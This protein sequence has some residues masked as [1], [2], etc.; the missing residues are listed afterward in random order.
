[1]TRKKIKNKRM[2]FIL[3]LLFFTYSISLAAQSS[4]EIWLDEMNLSAMTCGWDLPK[5]NFSV[6]GWQKIK[7]N[8]ETFER[9]VGSHA[10]SEFSISLD[11]KATLFSAKV[12]VDDRASQWGNSA[13]VIFKVYL[14]NKLAFVSDTMRA[15]MPSKAL[16]VNLKKAKIL[17]LVIDDAGDGQHADQADWAMAKIIYNAKKPKPT[18]EISESNPYL[19]AANI[20]KKPSINGPEIYG[21]RTGSPFLYRIPV[22][23]EKPISINIQGLPDGLTFDAQKRI[24]SGT[25]T[26]KGHYITTV[27]AKN[28]FGADKRSFE[29]VIGDTILLT[30]LMGW[31]SW[32]AY[33]LK[34]N[35]ETVKKVADFFESTGLVDYGYSYINID[36]GWQAESRDAQGKIQT[37]EKFP[38][39]K[40]IADYV[41]SKGLKFGI[42]SSPGPTTCGG[43]LGSYQHENEDAETYNQW[44]VDLLKYDWC[45]YD[46]VA[47]G[48]HSILSEMQ[49]P[50]ILMN[51]ALRTQKRDIVF[52]ICQYG[53]GNVWEWGSTVGGQMWR[54]TDDIR[55]AWSTLKFNTLGTVGLEKYAAPGAWN[56]PDLLVVGQM[57]WGKTLR[58]TRL[59]M[60][61]QYTQMTLWAML[62]A[63]LIISCDLETID[64]FTL[65]LLKNKEVIAINQ[66]KLGNQ[67]SVLKQEDD[68]IIL[69]KQL[70]G[71]RTAISIVNLSVKSKIIQLPLFEM[72]IQK[73][74]SFFDVWKNINI[75]SC[76]LLKI[77]IPAHD[78]RLFIVKNE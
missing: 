49:K 46:K 57:G 76:D 34:V 73:S 19:S 18:Y 59:K 43:F 48:G 3:Q 36:D 47:E 10:S 63:P 31:N 70:S 60:C 5:K 41:H 12:G 4:K 32:N 6:E 22:S 61:E 50:Y 20:E 62:S 37:N 67:A 68:I 44:G 29:I 75:K 66:D 78:S 54:T 77:S 33:G 35:G 11:G 69:K 9:G 24:I 27:T 21:A 2:K 13:S 23:G 15:N 65:N 45:S 51:K 14:D 38:D 39:M 1:V 56:D 40:G 30:P 74:I 53:F 7:L 55:D 64:D 42:Y 58:N 72:G 26:T 71:N 16:S 8:G 17:K 52:S 25:A 28:S